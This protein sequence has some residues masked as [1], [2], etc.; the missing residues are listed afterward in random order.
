MSTNKT[1]LVVEDEADLAEVVRYNLE[2]EGYRCRC[3]SDGL[4]A[5]REQS[6]SNPATAVRPSRKKPCLHLKQIPVRSRA[7]VA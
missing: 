4:S 1:V 5:L 2:R 6:T 7:W 3:V